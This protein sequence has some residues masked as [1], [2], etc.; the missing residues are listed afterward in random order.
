MAFNGMDPEFDSLANSGSSYIGMSDSSNVKQLMP[1]TFVPHSGIT[2]GSSNN[3]VSDFSNGK[4]LMPYTFD[5]NSSFTS[6]SSYNGVSHFSNGKQ[7]MP[8]PFDPNSSITSGS[9]YNGMSDLSNGNTF[10]PNSSM[11]SMSSI[12]EEFEN[13]QSMDFLTDDRPQLDFGLPWS[14]SDDGLD[15]QEEANPTDPHSPVQITEE[16]GNTLKRFNARFSRHMQGPRGLTFTQGIIRKTNDGGLELLDPKMNSWNFRQ[17][18]TVTEHILRERNGKTTDITSFHPLYWNRREDRNHWPEILYQYRPTDEDFN[19]PPTPEWVLD[20]GRVVIDCINHIMYDFPTLPKTIASS[21]PGW[22]LVAFIRSDLN[23]HMQD[24]RGRII[25]DAPNPK[26]K[27]DPLGHNKL[28]MRISRF[29]KLSGCLIWSK[30]AP[31]DDPL[32]ACMDRILPKSCLEAN[33]TK[34]FRDFY[35]HELEEIES[36]VTGTHKQ[37]RKKKT[38]PKNP[39]I[40]RVRKAKRSTLEKRKMSGKRPGGLTQHKCGSGNEDGYK[41]Q[42]LKKLMPKP[43]ID[44]NHAPVHQPQ[45]RN[46][47]THQAPDLPLRSDPSQKPTDFLST[48]PQSNEMKDIIFNLLT[49]TYRHF[50]AITEQCL[51]NSNDNL[52]YNDQVSEM[53]QTL[54]AWHVGNEKFG[55]PLELVR[56]KF[57]DDKVGLWNYPWIEDLFGSRL[58]LTCTERQSDGIEWF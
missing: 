51:P 37:L 54:T 11:T 21:V 49:P 31:K 4:Q 15:Y 20:D 55:K 39:D 56:L 18:L 27:D 36:K 33:S 42:V 41:E 48:V 13:L 34:C 45:S 38:I 3:G 30:S 16:M 29:R 19:K 32:K 6:G 17:K 50:N 23:I 47:A 57:L 44:A 35:P 43:N 14:M 12:N 10:Y 52:C 46:E 7:L 53:Q 26:N 58:T 1:Y 9:S 2:S 24:I 22:L 25:D 28:S 40:S 8:S 5:P